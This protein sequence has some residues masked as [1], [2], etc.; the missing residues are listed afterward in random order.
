MRWFIPGFVALI[1]FAACSSKDALLDVHDGAAGAGTG[2]G[3]GGPG[4]GGS[5]GKGGA[6]STGGATIP[7]TAGS[8]V[9]SGGIVRDGGALGSGGVTVPSAGGR[10]GASTASSGGIAGTGGILGGGGVTMASTGGRGDASIGG[11][12]GVAG[13]SGTGGLGPGGDGGTTKLDGGVADVGKDVPLG[14]DGGAVD[15]G[16]VA[17]SDL[18]TEASCRARGDCHPVFADMLV[19]GC[20]SP[21]CCIRF[22]RCTEGKVNCTPP[23][24]FTCTTSQP[25]C[26]GDYVVSYADGC[27][28]GCVPST[29]CSGLSSCSPAPQC[30]PTQV[31]V[32]LM[33]PDLGVLQCG[34]EPNPCQTSSFPDCDCAAELCTK[35]SG[36]QCI[37]FMP[38][39]GQLVCAENG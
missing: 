20:A 3:L 31:P 37:G 4:V 27:Y 34:C 7:G 5:M 24:Q 18:T 21:G 13:I 15:T 32:R 9:G 19:C 25:P 17:C 30:E 36:L 11:G 16:T 1:T 12:G 28:E 23:E 38:D 33:W 6:T 22:S 29:D 14:A 2:G 8:A 26:S 35:H 39:S 10:G